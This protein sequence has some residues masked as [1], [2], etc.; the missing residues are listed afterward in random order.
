MDIKIPMH[1][2]QKVRDPIT[3]ISYCQKFNDVMMWIA[4]YYYYY[5]IT[6]QNIMI[7]RIYN[8]WY[9]SLKLM[10]FYFQFIWWILYVWQI[11]IS[12][13]TARVQES[14]EGILYIYIYILIG[15]NTLQNFLQ[16]Y[17]TYKM[18][19]LSINHLSYTYNIYP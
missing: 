3:A 9:H 8:I 4:H 15:V 13:G 7:K 1:M 2:L 17:V 16:N 18:V 10:L 6:L 11:A 12:L 19:S 14:K 5:F